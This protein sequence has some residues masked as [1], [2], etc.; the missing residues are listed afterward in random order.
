M[1]VIVACGT[2]KRKE[3]SPAWKLYTGSYFQLCLR[4]ASKWAKRKDIYII[5]AKHGIV[6]LDTEL[7]PYDTHITSEDAVDINVIKSQM[8]RFELFGKHVVVFGGN[9]YVEVIQKVIPDA[10]APLQELK[11]KDKRMGYQMQMLKRW[12]Q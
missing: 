9:D 12:A 8:K 10:K 7:E 3:K 5:S 6:T 11:I 4:C 2:K 1:I